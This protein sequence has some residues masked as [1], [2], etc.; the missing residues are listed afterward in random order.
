MKKTNYFYT[1]LTIIILVMT[2][3]V[4]SAQHYQ[5][6]IIEEMNDAGWTLAN[7]RYANL[8]EGSSSSWWYRT[9]SSEREYRVVAFS[10]DEDV[11][12]VDLEIQ[13]ADGTPYKNDEDDEDLAVVYMSP[14][15]TRQYRIRIKNYE[16]LTPNFASKCYFMV[17]YR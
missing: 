13:Y 4:T 12:D 9:F 8:R 1:F 11:L 14:Y 17:F 7:N 6:D 10:D 5:S 2:A 15:I 3:Q 16:S